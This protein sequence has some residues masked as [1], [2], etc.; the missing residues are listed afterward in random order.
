[1]A[2]SDLPVTYHDSSPLSCLADVCIVPL[3]TASASIS[4][5]VFE[6]ENFLRSNTL[7]VK[8]TLHSAGTTL[9]G[10][11]GDVFNLIKQ[12]HLFCH[13][14]LKLVRLHT[15]IR[16]GSRIDKAQTASDKVET[17]ERKIKEKYGK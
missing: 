6:I 10:E 11:M 9:E 3:G 17:V 16:T 7:N 5:S 12:V 8:T 14:N 13:K 1:M 15:E 4:D 2:T